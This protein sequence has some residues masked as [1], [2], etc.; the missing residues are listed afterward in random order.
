MATRFVQCSIINTEIRVH[1]VIARSSVAN[2][3]IPSPRHRTTTLKEQSIRFPRNTS[4]CG[5]KR[6]GPLKRSS[7]FFTTQHHKSGYDGCLF[8]LNHCERFIRRSRQG[9]GADSRVIRRE[10]GSASFLAKRNESTLIQ[11]CGTTFCVPNHRVD[12]RWSLRRLESTIACNS[13]SNAGNDDESGDGAAPP[14]RH[15]AATQ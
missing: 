1:F 15:G 7:H 9:F 13:D 6:D 4:T 14:R 2:E 11:P 10:L 3:N 8:T 12:P 5:R